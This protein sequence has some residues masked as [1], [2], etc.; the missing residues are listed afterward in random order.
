MQLPDV[1]L[2]KVDN[3]GM[4]VDR[5]HC[6]RIARDLLLV[7]RIELFDLDMV[8]QAGDF[9]VGKLAAFNAGRL[10]DAFDCGHAAQ[11]R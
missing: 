2:G 4:A 8:Q 9:A 3:I 6:V 5:C 7:T 11:S 1:I 10:A